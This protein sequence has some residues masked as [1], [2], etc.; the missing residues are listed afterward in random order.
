MKSSKRAQNTAQKGTSR[1]KILNRKKILTKVHKVEGGQMRF[2]TPLLFS[3]ENSVQTFK[4][5]RDWNHFF[6]HQFKLINFISI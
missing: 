3:L 6:K 5:F 1:A 4:P 2:F